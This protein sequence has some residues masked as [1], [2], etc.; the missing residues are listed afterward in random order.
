MIERSALKDLKKKDSL[1]RHSNVNKSRYNSWLKAR[2]RLRMN[3][4]A[5]ALSKN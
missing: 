5:D 3:L 1:K 2:I 4:L